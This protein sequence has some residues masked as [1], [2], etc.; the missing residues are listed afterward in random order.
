MGLIRLLL[1]GLLVYIGFSLYKRWQAQQRRRNRPAAGEV[2]QM[3]RCE[4][5]G[6][7]LPREEALCSGDHCYCS[8]AHRQSA[9]QRD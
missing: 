3:V 9:Q 1:L 5:C 4:T 8:E 6:I 2:G 7:H